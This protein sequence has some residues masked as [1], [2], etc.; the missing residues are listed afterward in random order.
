MLYTAYITWAG[1]LVDEGLIVPAPALAGHKKE[2]WEKEHPTNQECQASP[3]SKVEE[4]L[5]LP[6]RG[7]GVHHRPGNLGEGQSCGDVQQCIPGCLN[8]QG[9]RQVHIVLDNLWLPSVHGDMVF[10][11]TDGF[12]ALT[13]WTPGADKQVQKH[14]ADIVFHFCSEAMFACSYL[15]QVKLIQPQYSLYQLQGIYWLLKKENFI[16]STRI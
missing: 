9:A 5:L 11:Y 8:K 13:T 7:E 15:H 16:W 10:E 6:G 4:S 12:N 1:A 2:D 14:M 3:H